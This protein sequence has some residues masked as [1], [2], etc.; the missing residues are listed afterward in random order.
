MQ[1]IVMP[2]EAGNRC[3]AQNACRLKTKYISPVNCASAER[4]A[5]LDLIPSWL[6]MYLSLN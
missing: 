6:H 2:V 4:A 1:K 3:T 5:E